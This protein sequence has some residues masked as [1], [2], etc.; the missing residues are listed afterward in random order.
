MQEEIAPMITDFEGDNDIK[1]EDID[2]GLVDPVLKCIQGDYTGRFVQLSNCISD[3][4]ETTGI[5]IG[6]GKSDYD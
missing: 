1:L 3:E 6:G 2:P 5:V 4:K